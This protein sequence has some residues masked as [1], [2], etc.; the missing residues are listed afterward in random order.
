MQAEADG[1]YYAATIVTVSEAKNRA[2][3]PVDDRNTIPRTRPRLLS[4]GRFSRFRFGKMC[5]ASGVLIFCRTFVLEISHDPG[6]RD[7]H[8]ETACFDFMRAGHGFW[9]FGKDGSS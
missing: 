1:T 4:V 2:K 3:A 8:F 7:L 5:R 6:I 9:G